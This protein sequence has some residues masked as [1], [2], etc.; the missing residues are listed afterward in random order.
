MSERK[1]KSTAIRIV[2]SENVTLD[3]VKIE[4]FDE[5]IVAER[6][7]MLEMVDV[8]IIE[9]IQEMDLKKINKDLQDQIDTLLTELGNKKDPE[10]WKKALV[11]LG[12]LGQQVFL[13]YLKA[14]RLIE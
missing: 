2:D 5:A 14:K 12:P 3:R 10:L 4:G 13:G 1:P 8:D 6:V 11:A 7:K 9:K